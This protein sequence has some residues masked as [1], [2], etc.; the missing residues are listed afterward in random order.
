MSAW[1]LD[2]ELLT[3]LISFYSMNDFIN[4]NININKG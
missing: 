2:S 4:V 3:C 1:F